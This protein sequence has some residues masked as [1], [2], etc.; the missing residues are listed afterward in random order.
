MENYFLDY[1][2]FTF[3]LRFYTIKKLGDKMDKIT[4]QLI[5]LS[6]EKYRLFQ[7]K[8]V[9]DNKYEILGIRVPILRNFA[10]KMEE[11][12]KVKFLQSL[13][14]SYYDENILHSILI[15]NMKDYDDIISRLEAFLPFVDNWAVCD[16]ISPKIMKKYPD[17]FYSF[18]VQ[19]T[20]S[21]HSYTMRFAVDMLLQFYLDE[22]FDE[23]HLSLVKNIVSE[24]YYVNM[25][26]AWYF[27][28]ALVK[29]YD[30]TIK[31]IEEKSM[32]KFV[33]NKSIQK[34]RESYK[35]DDET[36]KYLLNFKI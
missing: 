34:A 1:F 26:K 6:E 16:C 23:S 25:A 3:K 27:S 28:M 33:Q 9:P 21:K 12:D 32:D 14:H 11:S 5:S 13:P 22:H 7:E 15:S 35:I 29:Q 20:K 19:C 18:I 8:L 2:P 24:D 31:L 10:K 17:K 36:K 30:S 4:K